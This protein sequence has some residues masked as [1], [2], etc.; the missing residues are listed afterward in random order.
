MV[1]S[2]GTRYAHKHIIGTTIVWLSLTGGPSNAELTIL[3]VC[4]MYAVASDND[5]SETRLP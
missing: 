2:K 3:H 4:T 1:F 5:L